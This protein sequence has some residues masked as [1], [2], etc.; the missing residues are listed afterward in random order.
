MKYI[1]DGVAITLL[2]GFVLSAIWLSLKKETLPER[3]KKIEK[4]KKGKMD[5]T[6]YDLNGNPHL[7]S[8]FHNDVI[9]VNIWATWCAPCIEELPSMIRLVK[10]LEG[11]FTL[12][13]VT[14]ESPDAVRSFLNR[15]QMNPIPRFIVATSSEAYD[16]FNPAGLP[17]SFLFKKGGK[18]S[19]KII[20]PRTWDNLEWKN[21][22]QQL[23]DSKE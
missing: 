1:V 14:N 4:L 15:F 7:F 18:L 11:D 19:K 5:F 6:F 20:G 17:E 8:D 21:N 16:V 10:S 22:I 12:I 2:A 23:I 3:V 9:L 13:A